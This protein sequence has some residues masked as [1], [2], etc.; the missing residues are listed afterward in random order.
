MSD[1]VALNVLG[2]GWNAFMVTRRLK[3]PSGNWYELEECLR[4]VLKQNQSMGRLD[5]YKGRPY[6]AIAGAC[7]IKWE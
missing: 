7:L 4:K 6:K 2:Y 1:E 5:Y 3:P